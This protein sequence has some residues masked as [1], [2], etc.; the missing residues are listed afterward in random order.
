MQNA[1]LCVLPTRSENFGIVVAEALACGVPVITT[2]GAPWS[3]L[4]GNSDSSKVLKC[5]SAKVGGRA[6]AND[7]NQANED[8]SRTLELLNYR[9]SSGRSG[10]WIDIGVE[11]L[12][13]ALTEALA[14]TDEER[15]ALGVNGLRLVETKYTWPAVAV[16]MQQ[17]YQSILQQ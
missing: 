16:H 9:T 5:E 2:K 3:E 4:L 7:K 15:H 6:T 12:I 13:E 17:A 14:L 11:P 8:N 1:D 10:W